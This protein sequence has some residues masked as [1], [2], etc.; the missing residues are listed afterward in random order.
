VFHC[1]T[2][3]VNM[4]KCMNCGKDYEAKRSTSS[5]CSPACKQAFYRNRMVS[6]TG[7]SVTVTMPEQAY[8]DKPPEVLASRLLSKQGSAKPGE[9]DYPEQTGLNTCN[10]CGCKLKWDVLDT[11]LPCVV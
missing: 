8:P 9:P 3:M 11:C 6:V 2:V 7:E 4:A 10:R 1:P 5:Y